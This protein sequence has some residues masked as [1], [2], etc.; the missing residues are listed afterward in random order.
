[1]FENPTRISAI[2]A[3][4]IIE[5]SINESTATFH[6]DLSGQCDHESVPSILD[7]EVVGQSNTVLNPTDS[8]LDVKVSPVSSDDTVGTINL[9]CK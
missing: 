5:N 8:D 2:I 7:Y 9:K 4:H 1:M 6:Q 3:T